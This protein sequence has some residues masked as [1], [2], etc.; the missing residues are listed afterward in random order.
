[1]VEIG[2]ASVLKTVIEKHVDN[3]FFRSGAWVVSS[4]IVHIPFALVNLALFFTYVAVITYDSMFETEF[5]YILP[6]RNALHP[7]V[8][9]TSCVAMSENVHAL[10]G[11][12]YRKRVAP[13]SCL[14]PL[15]AGCGARVAY[16]PRLR[17]YQAFSH[18]LWSQ[19]SK[20]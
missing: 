13:A 10:E 20:R 4:A 7:C 12:A 14:P 16:A 6:S 2:V 17:L 15:Q 19:N 18:L 8:I 3:G 11:L 1:M 9:N 5:F